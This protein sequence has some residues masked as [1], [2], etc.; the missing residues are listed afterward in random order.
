MGHLPSIEQTWEE[1]TCPFCGLSI[2]RPREVVDGVAREMPVGCCTNCGAVYACD[3]TGHNLG[4]AFSEA[5][6]FA[7]DMDW[8]LAWDLLP[9][10]DYIHMIVEGYDPQTNRIYPEKIL[11]GHA[12][13]GALSFV[14]LHQDIQEVKGAG[15]TKRLAESRA[16]SPKKDAAHEPETAAGEPQKLTKQ[17]VEQCIKEYRLEPVVA[18]ARLDKKTGRYVQRLLHSNDELMRLRAAEALGRVAKVLA[19]VDPTTA[20]AILRGLFT[21]FETS[22]ASYWGS[23]DAI[24]EIMAAA[25]GLFGGYLPRLFPLLEDDALR[26]VVVRALTRIAQERPDLAGKAGRRVKPLLNSPDPETRG[27]AVRLFGYLGAD[28]VRERLLELQNDSNEVK[29]YQTGKLVKKTIGELARIA[30]SAEC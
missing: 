18:S 19:P 16:L 23:I 11:A 5:L 2:E 1:A 20:V 26:P 7:C 13:R 17:E 9:E 8:D 10:D 12:V 29:V 3:V 4:E 14:R 24:G 22:S 21:P 27:N 6:V 28:G 30:L 15:I 25:P